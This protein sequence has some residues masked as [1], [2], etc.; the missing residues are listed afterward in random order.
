MA[1]RYR[2]V[3]ICKLQVF[4]DGQVEILDFEDDEAR[5]NYIAVHGLKPFTVFEKET[6][7]KWQ[8][9]KK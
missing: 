8:K 1:D 2:R 5:D 3:P 7:Q 6:K 9:R 4:R